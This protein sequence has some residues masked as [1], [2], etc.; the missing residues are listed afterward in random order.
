M[1]SSASILDFQLFDLTPDL[2]SVVTFEMERSLPTP[3]VTPSAL[4]PLLFW[5]RLFSRTCLSSSALYNPAEVFLG[6][7][8]SASILICIILGA[9]IIR[10]L[11]KT[12]L[13]SQAKKKERRAREER[14]AY[15]KAKWEAEREADYAKLVQAI[16]RVKSLHP[17][18]E[19]DKYTKERLP[20][21]AKYDELSF[22]ASYKSP[23]GIIVYMSLGLS[24]GGYTING[25]GSLGIRQEETCGIECFR[26]LL[27]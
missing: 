20:K 6:E 2:R 10:S 15:W 14:D 22:S 21:S 13:K 4:R 12:F 16:E 9:V 17:E 3:Q 1:F 25:K 18:W 23:N 27:L 24:R 8:V 11:L 19:I 5:H 26:N 7:S